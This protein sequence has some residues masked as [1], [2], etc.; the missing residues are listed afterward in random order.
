MARKLYKI[1]S[2][3]GIDQDEA[4]NALKPAYSPDACNMDTAGGD[5]AVAKGYIRHIPHQIPGVGQPHRLFL[6]RRAGQDQP[7]VAAGREL[8][9]YKNNA[10]ILIHTFEKGLASNKLDFVQAQIDGVDYLLIASG[11]DP[12]VKYNG[13]SALS[14]GSEQGQSNKPVQYLAMYRDRL[15]AAGDPSYPNRL[16]WSQLPGSGRTIE[17]WGDVTDTVNVSGGHAEVGDAAGDPILGLYALSNQLLIFKKRSLY[18]LIGDKPGNFTIERVDADVE[19]A[20]HTALVAQGDVLYFLTA[21]GLCCFNGVNAGLL[22]DARR[23]HKTLAAMD[24]SNCRGALARNKLYFTLSG[25]EEDMLVEYDLFRR[26]YM[27]RRGFSIGDIAAWDGRLYMV[28]DARYLYRIDEGDTYDGA[29]IE[30]WWNTPLTDLYDKGGVKA[31]RSLCLRG[32][33]QQD[34]ALLAEVC[35]DGVT[36]TH[37]LLLPQHPWEVLEVP[38]CNEGRTFRLAFS[39]EAGGRFTLTGGVELAFETWRRVE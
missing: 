17:A 32:Q 20:A 2:F 26:A 31:M 39:N 24:A 14:F 7:I 22:S 18:R 13:N 29:D 34:A 6:F 4:E 1:D 11:E 36:T 38:L 9:A 25:P 27:F 37:R 8:Y 3:I 19:Q 10:W 5:L 35:I 30:A 16:Y 15:F 12:I 23:I 28:N 33:S 21:G